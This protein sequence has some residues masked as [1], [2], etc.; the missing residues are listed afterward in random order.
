MLVALSGCAEALTGP[1]ASVPTSEGMRISGSKRLTAVNATASEFSHSGPSSGF[2]EPSTVAGAAIPHVTSPT[3]AHDLASQG[4]SRGDRKVRTATAE[5]QRDAPGFGAMQPSSL[6]GE[7]REGHEAPQQ[8]QA[9]RQTLPP[10]SP[11][12]LLRSPPPLL[13]R[14][15]PPPRPP[16]SRPPLQPQQ[17]RLQVQEAQQQQQLP[18]TGVAFVHRRSLEQNRSVAAARQN[19]SAQQEQP[20]PASGAVG[21]NREALRREALDAHPHRKEVCEAF[22]PDEWYSQVAGNWAVY[23]GEEEGTDYR[24]TYRWLDTLKA[25]G[26]A[27]DFAIDVGAHAGTFSDKVRWRFPYAAFALLDADPNLVSSWLVPGYSRLED[28]A[29]FNRVLD[30]VSDAPVQLLGSGGVQPANGRAA[31]ADSTAP[32]SA[33]GEGRLLTSRLDDVIPME[34]PPSLRMRWE[35]AA[36]VFLKVDTEGMDELVLRGFDAALSRRH[37]RA[38]VQIVQLEFS[39]AQMREVNADVGAYNLNST[40]SFLEARGFAVFWIGPNFVPITH[41]AWTDK[42]LELAQQKPETLLGPGMAGRTMATDL[43]AVR[44]DY[45]LLP[46]LRQLLGSCAPKRRKSTLI[47]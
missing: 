24:Q 26:G 14:S 41:G 38:V 47:R 32:Q 22:S 16:P 8:A 27:I 3:R 23:M 34:L 29:V 33:D 15:P 25:L 44:E 31:A 46:K 45:P 12:L 18:T 30:N 17:Q 4:P 35:A 37:G 40:R 21:L 36:C 20:P 6:H 1:M 13:L 28:T 19:A 42:Y 10:P 9:R 11:S 7:Q 2:G 39:P 5:T 43:L